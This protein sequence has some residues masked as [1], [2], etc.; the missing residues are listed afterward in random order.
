LAKTQT[1]RGPAQFYLP[2]Y[3][4]PRGWIGVRLGPEGFVEAVAAFIASSFAIVAPKTLAAVARR[5]VD[6]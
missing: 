4:E 3:I 2:A 5:N 1:W 6:S